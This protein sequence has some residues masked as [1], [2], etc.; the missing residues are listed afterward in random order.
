LIFARENKSSLLEFVS[1]WKY[2]TAY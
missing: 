1:E 2:H